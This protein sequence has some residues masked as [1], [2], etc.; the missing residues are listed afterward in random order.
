MWAYFSFI[1]FFWF[2]DIN[3]VVDWKLSQPNLFDSD[4]SIFINI[5]DIVAPILF[6]SDWSWSY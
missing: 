1:S 2:L 3:A 6:Q 5:I 4:A